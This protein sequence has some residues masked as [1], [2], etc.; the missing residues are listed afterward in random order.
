MLNGMRALVPDKPR[1]PG[2]VSTPKY[3]NVNAQQFQEF[4]YLGKV[5]ADE[6]R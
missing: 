4:W 1:K 5:L 6:D 2:E 3:Q